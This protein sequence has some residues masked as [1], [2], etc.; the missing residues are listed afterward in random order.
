MFDSFRSR[1]PVSDEQWNTYQDYF[2]RR[3]IPARTVLL[4]ERAIATKAYYIEKGAVRV[5]FDH[6]GSEIT[7]QFFFEHQA[8]SSIESFRKSI[9]SRVTIETIE[10][11]VLW[12]IERQD[13]NRILEEVMEIKTLRDLVIDMLFERT[14][15]YMDHFL[16]FIRDTPE[17]RY[18]HLLEQSPH[19]VKR[20]PQHYIASYLGISSVHLSRI[21]GKIARK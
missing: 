11:S 2:Q 15:H 4:A 13:I 7:S 16:S 6:N 10:P 18:L 8:V 5:W 3:E 1:F 14:F 20:V 19:V 17:Q 12:E 9:P 21:K